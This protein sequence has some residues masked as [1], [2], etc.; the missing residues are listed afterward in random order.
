A[1]FFSYFVMTIFSWLWGKKYYP[2]PYN[3]T[4]NLVY[5]SIGIFIY[6][7]FYFAPINNLFIKLIL[8]NAT[9]VLFIALAFGRD[10]KKLLSK[11]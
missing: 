9:L 7:V 4:K 2:V 8:A 10:I 6:L 1:T 3:I 11:K 5:I